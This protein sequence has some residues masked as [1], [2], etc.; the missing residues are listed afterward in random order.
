MKKSLL[1]LTL[2]SALLSTNL[3]V[4]YAQCSLEV[5]E[6]ENKGNGI[7]EAV[8]AF[9]EETGC[10]V[11]ISE[12]PYVN[13]INVMLDA[14]ETKAVP[15]PDIVMLPADRMG[16]AAK[17]KLIR[18][19]SFMQRDQDRYL[20]SSIKSFTYKGEIYASP[21]S[22]ETMVI[23]YNQDLLKYPFEFMED[24]YNFAKEIKKQGKYGIISK[25]DTIYYAYGFLRGFGGYCFKQNEDGTLDPNDIGLDNDGAIAG[26]EYLRKFVDNTVPKSILGDDGYAEIDK[27][28]VT[29]QVAA[30]INGPWALDDYAK[31]GLN[32]G[33]A[34]LPKLPNGEYAHPFLGFR[35]YAVTAFS[36]NV[37]LAEKFLRFIN[38]DEFALKRY[39]NIHEIP[40]LKTIMHNPLILNDD[41]ASAIAM[42]ALHA[43][44]TPSIPEMA[45][46]WEPMNNAL[47]EALTTKGSIKDA[48]VKGANKAREDIKNSD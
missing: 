37:E 11:K 41:F 14:K 38:Q 9:E 15:L 5:W 8:A 28:F 18:P 30:V 42:Q 34:P 7:K 36:H 23:Y 27:L 35:G 48:L 6:D 13:H 2:L 12:S 19:L 16:D 43:E 22:V 46:I 10:T 26:A 32:Y 3:P 24:Y 31:S 17:N 20:L 29:G 39:E 45:K 21:R 33:V 4:S 1:S 25:W 47:Y 40:P 44:P